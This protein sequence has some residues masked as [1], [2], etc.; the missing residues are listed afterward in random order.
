M[1]WFRG[2]TRKCAIYGVEPAS[3]KKKFG[4]RNGGEGQPRRGRKDWFRGAFEE[5]AEKWQK[6]EP[7]KQR[8]RTADN[9]DGCEEAR[10]GRSCPSAV[11]RVIRGDLLVFPE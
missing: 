7:G 5:S 6:G 4:V 9:A 2:L 8:I 1:T 10:P 3:M 11:I